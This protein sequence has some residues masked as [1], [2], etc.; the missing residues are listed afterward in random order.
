M[1]REGHASRRETEAASRRLAWTQSKPLYLRRR[2]AGD[3]AMSQRVTGVRRERRETES[4]LR[5]L[6]SVYQRGFKHGYDAA[7]FAASACDSLFPISDLARVNDESEDATRARIERGAEAFVAF[8]EGRP[9][10]I[11]VEMVAQSM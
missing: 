10:I 2:D 3:V 5:A 6:S 7:F 11:D 9:Q 8:A 4:I 1:I